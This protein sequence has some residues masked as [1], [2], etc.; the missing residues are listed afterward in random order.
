MQ[1]IAFEYA[2]R[3]ATGAQRVRLFRRFDARLPPKAGEK[4]APPT[5]SRT[6]ARQGIAVLWPSSSHPAGPPCRRRRAPHRIR[7]S[8]KRL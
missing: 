1:Q 6:G 3:K 2:A 5:A 7:R 4:T 8:T